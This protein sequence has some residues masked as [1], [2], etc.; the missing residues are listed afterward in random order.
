MTKKYDLRYGHQ[1]E[2]KRMSNDQAPP[3]LYRAELLQAAKT[4]RTALEHYWPD[5]PKDRPHPFGIEIRNLAASTKLSSGTIQAALR[6]D[7]SK[8][9][10][11]KVLADFFGI[12]WLMLFDVDRQLSFDETG[13]PGLSI[14]VKKR[15]LRKGEIDLG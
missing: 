9:E 13:R 11:L 14:P 3:P 12:P 8:I 4:S 5:A 1:R 10:T 15:K 7:A 2:L 6:G